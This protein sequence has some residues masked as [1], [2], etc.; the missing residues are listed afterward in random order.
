MPTIN[1]G[2]GTYGAEGKGH[3]FSNAWKEV[4]SPLIYID[5]RFQ[6][7]SSTTVNDLSGN[8]NNFVI[9]TNT[10]TVYKTDAYGNPYYDLNVSSL[11]PATFTDQYTSQST[12]PYVTYVLWT[13][14][15][16]NPY[17]PSATP[18]VAADWRTLTRGVNA[19]H[20][21]IVDTTATDAQIGYYDNGTG[22]STG[23]SGF[24]TDY[25]NIA[26]SGTTTD[27][28]QSAGISNGT[29]TFMVIKFQASQPNQQIFINE[30]QTNP[31][32]SNPYSG[33]PLYQ[34]GTGISGA[35]GW[36][37]IISGCCMSPAANTLALAQAAVTS[38]WWGDIAAFAAYGRTLTAA[39]CYEIY[40]RTR[41]TYQSV[42]TMSNI[43]LRD[44]T[45]SVAFSQQL[46]PNYEFP[47]TNY[48]ITSGSLVTGLSMTSGGLITG[49]PT[50]SST[51]FTVQVT[52]SNGYV[53]NFTVTHNS[54]ALYSASFPLT[55]T[56]GGA[57]G[58]SGPNLSQAISGLGSPSWASNTAFFSMPTNGYQL[59]TVPASG[60]YQIT[61]VGAGLNGSG[62]VNYGATVTQTFAL[63]SGQKLLIVCGQQGGMYAAGNGGT[64]VAIGTTPGSN[65]PILFAGGGGSKS[66]KNGSLAAN[67]V[68]TANDSGQV[69][70]SAGTGGPACTPNGSWSCGGGGYSGNGASCGNGNTGGTSFTNGGTGGNSASGAAYGGFGAG[71][72]SGGHSN[73]EYSAGG[74]YT[75]AYAGS[76]SGTGGGGGG[77]YS[78]TGSFSAS[79]N[80]NTGT[81]YVIINKV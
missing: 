20:H 5:A 35:T 43:R 45:T 34:S 4:A 64:G 21:S 81:G 65:T 52:F 17:N 14:V 47:A 38:Q 23:K 75:G 28:M 40:E 58:Q 11:L 27:G 13:R 15:K 42:P 79:S 39:E 76:S 32:L 7:T 53:A 37:G 59:W 50:G 36:P 44:F 46:Q 71:G 6:N 22:N 2:R 63:S 24:L 49:T 29:W 69:N 48:T 51:T 77:S 31:F 30:Q 60:N 12:Y 1:S 33:H 62:G 55:F 9:S 56:T 57:N 10:A 26:T 80:S 68:S 18:A 67:G 66:G 8:G 73:F 54:N 78:S 25:T 70:S 61:A 16:P 41:H 19:G 72:A 74:G 3:P